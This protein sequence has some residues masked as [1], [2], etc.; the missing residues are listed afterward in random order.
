MKKPDK[1]K[2]FQYGREGEIIS[3]WENGDLQSIENF[4]NGLRHGLLKR[5]RMDNTVIMIGQYD[6]NHR[7]GSWIW[8]YAD[9]K[10]MKEELYKKSPGFPVPIVKKSIHWLESGQKISE[11]NYKT[12]TVEGDAPKQ[13]HGN[14]IVWYDNGN[15]KQHSIYKSNKLDGKWIEWHRNGVKRKS[16]MSEVSE[17]LKEEV[18]L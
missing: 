8:Y 11:I 12:V 18:K 16:Q 3:Y 9:G 17:M 15:K 6:N 4:K 2:R 10:K 7:Y 1:T 14:Y 13:N 5:Y